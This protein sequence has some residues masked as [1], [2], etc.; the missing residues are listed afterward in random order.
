MGADSRR[1]A[2]LPACLAPVKTLLHSTSL[3]CSLLDQL[4]HI[5]IFAVSGPGALLLGAA[6]MLPSR[7]ACSNT[8]AGWDLP[9]HQASRPSALLLGAACLL[10]SR[11]AIGNPSA[12]CAVCWTCCSLEHLDSQCIPGSAVSGCW[13]C[14][15]PVQK[16]GQCAGLLPG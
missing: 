9:H 4:D 3:H 13:A 14:M 11:R 7:G 2:G 10:S 5:C 15:Q 6:C 8:S 12:S 16:I 1:G